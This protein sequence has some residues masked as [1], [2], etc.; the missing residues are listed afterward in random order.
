MTNA[1]DLFREQHDAARQVH[2]QLVEVAALMER[3]RAQ[4]A[5]IANDRELR[6]ILR[7]ERLWLEAAQRATDDVRQWRIEEQRRYWPG[8]AYRWITALSFALL[9][10]VAVGTGYGWI[11]RPDAIELEALRPHA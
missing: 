3:L 2:A 11:A 6:E 8:V 1:L 7:E 10:A 9:S 5:A 4:I